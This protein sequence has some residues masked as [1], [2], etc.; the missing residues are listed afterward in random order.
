MCARSPGATALSVATI[1]ACAG[2]GIP[3]APSEAMSNMDLDGEAE[4]SCRRCRGCGLFADVANHRGVQMAAM[5]ASCLLRRHSSAGRAALQP[6]IGVVLHEFRP[7]IAR[8]QIVA[9]LA[10]REIRAA[11]IAHLY[12]AAHIGKRT[13]AHRNW[14]PKGG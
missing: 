11:S 9:S 3:V 1:P 5:L 13:T 4:R 10:K 8:N 7:R 12:A 6:G 2:S 14:K